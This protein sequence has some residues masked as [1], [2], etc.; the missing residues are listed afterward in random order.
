MSLKIGSLFCFL[1]IGNPKMLSKS[2][3]VLELLK[4]KGFS[5][6]HLDK[7]NI[8]R[9]TTTIK[10]LYFVLRCNEH[11][12]VCCCW[13][14]SF[15]YK[16]LFFV[17][18]LWGEWLGVVSVFPLGSY[19]SSWS[20]LSRMSRIITSSSHPEIIRDGNWKWSRDVLFE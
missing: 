7:S 20:R 14:W 13:L 8:K 2:Y 19:S 18:Y 15:V 11:E 12:C 6:L 9:L 4:I 1:A 16:D 17:S 10:T 3:Y 5:L